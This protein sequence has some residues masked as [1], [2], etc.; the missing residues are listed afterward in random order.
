M[1]CLSRKCKEYLYIHGKLIKSLVKP[2][3][4]PGRLCLHAIQK[5]DPKD[6]DS[7]ALRLGTWMHL[8]WTGRNACTTWVSVMLSLEE[9]L[10]LALDDA[11]FNVISRQLILRL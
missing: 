8:I 3:K 7:P 6:F 9:R 4:E 5:G 11:I 1:T 10:A 2:N